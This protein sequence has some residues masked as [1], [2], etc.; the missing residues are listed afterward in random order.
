M[1]TPTVNEPK[2]L[3]APTQLAA[4]VAILYTS[5][6]GQKG[7]R[8]TEILLVNDTTT[9]A[10]VTL[11]HVPAAGAPGVTNLIMNAASVPGDGF[12]VIINFRG[13][14]MNANDTIRGF[15]SAANQITI[16]LSGI[17]MN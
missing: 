1:A 6:A 11:Y 2:R 8:L 17:E 7:T 9:A 15:A 3:I 4:G 14:V 16:H 10:T 5:P 12:P 13:H